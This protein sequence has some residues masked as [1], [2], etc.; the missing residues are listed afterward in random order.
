MRKILSKPEK[1]NNDQGAHSIVRSLFVR[2]FTGFE[3]KTVGIAL[4]IN[5]TNSLLK[6]LSK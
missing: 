2:V 4:L 6:L 1:S 5:W 3:K